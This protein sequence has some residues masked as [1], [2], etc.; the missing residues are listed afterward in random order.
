MDEEDE[1]YLASYNKK[2]PGEL[3][4]ED[5]FEKVMWE[6]E[7]ITNQQWPHLYLVSN[8]LYF[9]KYILIY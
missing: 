6:C 8:N 3:L 4:S 9:I 5:M 1:E 7:S 2:H